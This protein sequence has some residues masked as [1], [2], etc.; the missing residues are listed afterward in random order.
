MGPVAAELTIPGVLE[1]T[2]LATPAATALVAEAG[3]RVT[4]D[5]LY[6]QVRVAAS[7][8]IAMGVEPGRCVAL[9]APNSVE[10]VVASLATACV[11]AALVP[12]NTRWRV[13][14]VLDLV[15]RADCA[16]WLAADDFLGNACG[17]VGR[18]RDRAGGA[19]RVRRPGDR[20][21]AR[22]RGSAR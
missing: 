17:R 15:R 14:E 10:W 21:R 18:T 22:R 19:R 2:R 8:L 4:Y 6:E 20:R 16:L 5:E 1:R 3:A 13:G 11:G 9:W 7:A 12:F